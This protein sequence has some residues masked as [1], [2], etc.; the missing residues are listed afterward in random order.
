MRSCT[1]AQVREQQV[2][3]GVARLHTCSTSSFNSRSSKIKSDPRRPRPAS[4][5]Q[6][7]TQ[8]HTQIHTMSGD[9]AC[10]DIKGA[11]TFQGDVLDVAREVRLQCL[12]DDAPQWR[13]QN[14]EYS[15]HCGALLRVLRI[16]HVP[17]PPHHDNIVGLCM[18]SCCA[19]VAH[20]MHMT[21]KPDMSLKCPFGI[22]A[23]QTCSPATTPAAESS[24]APSSATSGTILVSGRLAKREPVLHSD[25]SFG[26][27]SSWQKESSKRA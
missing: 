17:Q 18:T 21:H 1:Y 13:G 25:L 22:T 4:H 23:T 6:P 26:Q 15:G 7:P 19:C 11:G 20:T 8:I 2:S 3:R 10:P 14:A 16:S 9:R 12:G 5:H 27:L 24:A